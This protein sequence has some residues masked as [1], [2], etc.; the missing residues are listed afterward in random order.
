MRA[1]DLAGGVA[2]H[3]VGDDEERELLVDE[4]VVLVVLADAAHVGRGEEADVL[5]WPIRAETP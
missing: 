1:R 3:A 5:F 2:A 4:V